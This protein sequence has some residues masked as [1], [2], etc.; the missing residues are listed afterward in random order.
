MKHVYTAV[1]AVTKAKCKR[2]MFH[3]IPKGAIAGKMPLT[4]PTE[5]LKLPNLK[6]A[7]VGSILKI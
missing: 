3:I 5:Y 7:V 6:Y 1:L 4:A 2:Y